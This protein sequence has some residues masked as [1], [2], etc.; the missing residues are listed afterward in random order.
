MKRAAWNSFLAE[1]HSFLG[2]HKDENY[3][4]LVKTDKE[5]CYN[6]LQDVVDDPCS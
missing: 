1:V 3:A 6:G 2:N 4:K 5:L